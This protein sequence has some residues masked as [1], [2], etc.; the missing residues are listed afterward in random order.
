MSAKM[1]AAFNSITELKIW[2]KDQ[3]GDNLTL[4]DMSELI[5]LRWG[6]FK[7]RWE[8][9]KQSLLAKSKNYYHPDLLVNQVNSMSDFINRQK[10]SSTQNLNPFSNPSIIKEYYALWENIDVSSIPI[11]RQEQ[12]IIDEKVAH[13]SRFVKTDFVE[14]R[15]NIIQARD[16]LADIIG[17]SDSSYNSAKSGR[18]S[19]TKLREPRIK[20]IDTMVLLH[21]NIKALDFILANISSL[22]TISIDPFTLARQ[23]ADNP[24]LQIEQGVSGRLVKMNYGDSLQDIAKREFGNPDRW[25][26][27]AIANGLKPPYV[28]EIGIKVPLLAN[29]DANQINVSALD[30][31]GNYNIDKF[32]VNQAV[33]LRSDATATDDQRTVL[34]IREVP[35]SG[36]IILE[37]DGEL[38]LNKY[39]SVDNAYV[40]VFKSNT[41]NSRFLILV[42]SQ[43]PLPQQKIGSEPFFIKSLG[44]DEKNAGIDLAINDDM[45]LVFSS[46]NDLDYSFGLNNA[47]QAIKYKMLT[48]Q[49]QLIRH[50]QFGLSSVVGKQVK[51]PDAIRQSL[52][53]SVSDAINSD[54]RFSRIERL[55]VSRSN[56]NQFTIKLS[57]RMAGTGTVVPI[58]FSINTG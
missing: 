15:D 51:E 42:P 13:I 31:N 7:E 29:G 24:D 19:I 44:D 5:P 47:V 3:Q 54:P 17:L 50:P 53:S 36:D 57:V 52:V 41:A 30:S 28:D 4:A 37:L 45:D 58:S 34:N 46:T 2:L 43:Q 10:G 25:I 27:I 26:E 16:E 22:E 35:I 8:F 14:I 20:D 21:K 12:K 40:R 39:R 6:F 48:E 1:E 38:N 9:I 55:D 23:N 56:P 49:G 33:F 32:Y 11:S 18:G